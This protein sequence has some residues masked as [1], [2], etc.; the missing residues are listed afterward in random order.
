MLAQTIFSWNCMLAGTWS[1]I[2]IT[3][4]HL[5]SSVEYVLIFSMR[6]WEV[7]TCAPILHSIAYRN[8]LSFIFRASAFVLSVLS[9]CISMLQ[10]HWESSLS[11]ML[12]DQ[13]LGSRCLVQFCACGL[14]H[15]QSEERVS[16]ALCG[17]NWWCTILQI[18]GVWRV[19]ISHHLI[20]CPCRNFMCSTRL[21]C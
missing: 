17:T 15:S 3:S 7:V 6:L 9:I 8:R 10:I 21:L 14:L 11:Q 13:P 16:S 12:S 2:E 19:G 18:N 5:C 20:W 1:E 4:P